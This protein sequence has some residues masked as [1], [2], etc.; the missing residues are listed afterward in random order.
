M[1]GISPHPLYRRVLVSPVLTWCR[2][3]TRQLFFCIHIYSLRYWLTRRSTLRMPYYRQLNRTLFLLI[4]CRLLKILP[5]VWCWPYHE[6]L[7]ESNGPS[8]ICLAAV[9]PRIGHQYI[10][11]PVDQHHGNNP[12]LCTYVLEHVLPLQLSRVVMTTDACLMARRNAPIS[13]PNL[14]SHLAGVV[15]PRPLYRRLVDLVRWTTICN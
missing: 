9:N 5:G 4:K 2:L 13:P 14:P 1:D 3:L 15:L 12:F 6:S 11:L 7:P 10:Q 8:E